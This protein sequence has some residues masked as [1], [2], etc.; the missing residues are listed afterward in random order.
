MPRRRVNFYWEHGIDVVNH[1][2]RCFFCCGMWSHVIWPHHLYLCMHSFCREYILYSY[3]IF[4]FKNRR[5]WILPHAAVRT[6]VLWLL[7]TYFWCHSKLLCWRILL[8]CCLKGDPLIQIWFE[9]LSGCKIRQLRCWRMEFHYQILCIWGA[10]NDK[11]SSSSTI[12][13]LFLLWFLQWF[14]VWS[15]WWNSPRL[16]LETSAVPEPERKVLQCQQPICGKS[17]VQ[18]RD[19]LAC[20]GVFFIW[21]S[22]AFVPFFHKLGT[23]L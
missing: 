13:S 17:M 5:Y 6:K 2:E 4:F 8:V 19:A 3:E 23:I 7:P 9:S 18:K 14:L 1:C 22:L 16:L 20:R 15:T 10:W 12:V 11:L 21:K